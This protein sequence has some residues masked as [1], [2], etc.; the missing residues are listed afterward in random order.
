VQHRRHRAGERA[1]EF[2]PLACRHDRTGGEP[3]GLEHASDHDRIDREDLTDQR[4]ASATALR[5]AG[6]RHGALLRL[7][8]RVGEHRAGEDILGLGVRRHAEARHIDT[9]DAHTVDLFRQQV[10]GHTGGGRHA[11]VDQHDGVVLV[12][13]GELVG[14]LAQVLEQ[15]AGHQGLGIEGH[16]ADGALGAVEVRGEGQAVDAAGASRTA[17]SPCAH[18]QA[19]AQGTEGRAH[20]LRLI[21][22]TR[23]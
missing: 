1:V 9:D 4:H 3:Q 10:Q 17:P 2:A 11:E 23:G 5:P 21:V 6:A 14:R 12:R 8:A 20:A 19:D 15:L 18:T 13:I 7:T 22:G 16:V